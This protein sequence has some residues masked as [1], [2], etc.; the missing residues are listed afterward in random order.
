MY[1][2]KITEYS[3]VCFVKSGKVKEYDWETFCNKISHP[4]V[5]FGMLFDEY[6][7]LPKN[8]KNRDEYENTQAGIKE[9]GGGAVYG[10]MIIPENYF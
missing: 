7:S 1:T 3:G 4:A 6:L 5:K 8:S 10:E 2:F 9:L